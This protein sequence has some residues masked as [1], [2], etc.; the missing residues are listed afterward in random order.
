[1]ST[2]VL[3]RGNCSG[4][5]FKFFH[6]H[7]P[8]LGNLAQGTGQLIR[9]TNVNEKQI[10]IGLQQEIE[11]AGIEMQH[12]SL[13]SGCPARAG[14]HAKKTAR[15]RTA[16]SMPVGPRKAS[17]FFLSCRMGCIISL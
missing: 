4:F 7:I 11:A 16:T 17:H 2:R 1:M 5:F 15:A 10:G 3:L 13:R 9:C 8:R 12:L 6:G 14:S